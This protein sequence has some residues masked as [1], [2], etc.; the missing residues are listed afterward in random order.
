MTLPP[1]VTVPMTD[2][3]IIA[4]PA[5]IERW[6]ACIKQLYSVLF[7]STK[8][9]ANS[10][11]VRFAG[12]PGAKQ[13]PDEQ[14]LA[15]KTKAKKYLNSSMQRRR[16]VMRKLNDMVMMPNQD[17]GISATGRAQAHW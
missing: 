11:L 13:Q 2:E 9:A 17:P 14:A 16:I 1:I 7:L 8:G 15:G 4:N 12:R 10:F 5:E 6:D 3:L